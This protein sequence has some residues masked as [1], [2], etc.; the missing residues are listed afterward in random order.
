M[1]TP[2]LETWI[3]CMRNRTR[4]ARRDDLSSLSVG[5]PQPLARTRQRE[6]LATGS[7]NL[8]TTLD[9]PRE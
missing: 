1:H 7:G 9:E 2:S 5:E 8:D 4:L 6:L 3:N